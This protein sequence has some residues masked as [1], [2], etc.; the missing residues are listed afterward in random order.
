MLYH[1]VGQRLSKERSIRMAKHRGSTKSMLTP[2]PC[3]TAPQ[4][5]EAPICLPGPCSLQRDNYLQIGNT[6]TSLPYTKATHGVFLIEATTECPDL[7]VIGNSV[8]NS[9]SLRRFPIDAQERMRTHCS[10]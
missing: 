5:V 4:M 9:F 10:R 3:R 7:K 2:H 1:H 8:V 6:A